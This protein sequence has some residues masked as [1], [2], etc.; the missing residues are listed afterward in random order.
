V[1]DPAE[2]HSM[3]RRAIHRP[4]PP[5]S[6]RRAA[7][8]AL[9]A[10]AALAIVACGG[11]DDDGS[12]GGA[13]AG[14]AGEPSFRSPVDVI[15]PFSPAS[16]SD[17]AARLV[18]PVLEKALGV[19]FQ[20]TN[21]PGNTGNDGMTRLLRS[22]ADTTV[23]VIPAD[24]LATLAAGTSSFQLGDVS[25]VCRLSLAPSYLWVRANGRYRSWAQLARAV[26]ARPGRLTV[27]TVGRR[28]IDDIMLGALAQQGY[29]FRAVPYAENS[30]RR[31]ALLDGHVDAL[32]EQAGDVQEN[33]AAGQFA[34]VLMFGSRRAGLKGD[35]ALSSEVGVSQVVDQ[36]RGMF[37][38]ATMP[39]ARVQALS[40]A[41]RGV[42]TD[43][44]FRAFHA[45]A[46]ERPGPYMP[47]QQFSAFVREEL[48]RMQTLARRYGV[49]GG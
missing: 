45:R 47:A 32:F 3:L 20:V 23:A 2:L 26:R 41:C 22:P 31:G 44:A 19:P 39:G 48:R 15:V 16:G 18:S 46:F 5:T 25:P 10:V 33:L 6:G 8:L 49:Y 4:C 36:W 7:L 21:E 37:A 38:R 13:A 12:G 17:R 24:T 11:G 29:R 28:G 27:A 43:P 30:R 42:D 14:R 9:L 40:R 1:V 35:Y 34:P